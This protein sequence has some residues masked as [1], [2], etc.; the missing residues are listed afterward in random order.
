MGIDQE[1]VENGVVHDEI[2]IEDFNYDPETGIF[3]YPCP[4]GDEFIVL[5][6]SLSSG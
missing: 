1:S 6:V 3:T 4:C 5:K 2:E